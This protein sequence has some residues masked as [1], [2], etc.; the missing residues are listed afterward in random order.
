VGKIKKR[1]LPV[2]LCLLLCCM[3]SPSALAADE[4]EE[5]EAPAETV[6]SIV[7]MESFL[8]FAENCRLDTYSQ[9]LHVSL[10][11]DLDFS[12]VD[13]EPVPIFSG[14]LEGNGHTISG[15]LLERDGSVQGLFR[16]LT[17]EALVQN[18][19]VKAE[20]RP[21]GSHNNVGGIV[22]S[23]AG[24]I[25]NCRFY[26]SVSGGDCV[27]GIAGVNTMTGIIER[28]R[29]SGNVTGSHFVGGLVGDNAGVVRSSSNSAHVNTTPAENTVDLNDI[30]LESIS[31]TESVSTVTD[32]GGIAGISS[33][34]IRHSTNRG[35]V[36]YQQMGYNIGGIAGTQK[37]YI[38]GCENFGSVNGRKEVGGIVGQ[39]EPVIRVLYTKDT[40]QIL[41]EQL[42]GM[43][44]IVNQASAHT[45]SGTAA[46]NGQINILSGQVGDAAL[47]VDKLLDDSGYI[48]G[49]PDRDTMQAIENTL[50]ASMTD[51]NVT[52]NNMA[53]ATEK[54]MYALVGDLQALAGQI[55][56]MS[57]TI[58][59][60]TENV[61]MSFRDVSDQDTP[62][63]LSGKV[64][65]CINYGPVLAD[66]NAGGV[67]GA[68]APENDLNG[69]ENI[70]YSGEDSMNLENEFRAVILSCDNKADV[71][72]K[73][74]NGGGVVGW[75]SMGLVYEC[76]NIGT[77]DAENADY[78][79][80]IAGSGGGF[81]RQCYSSCSI[82]GDSSLGGIAGKGTIVTDCR[83]MVTLEG[84]EKIGGILGEA[85]ESP[86]LPEAT[87]S[88]DADLLDESEEA[89]EK[90][91]VS[92]NFYVTLG[93]DIGA[94]DGIS[95]AG[96]AEPLALDAFMQ[97]ED[98]PVEFGTVVVRFRFE[99][100]TEKSISLVPGGKLK[101]SQL[102]A[103]PEKAGFTGCWS[104][105]EEA[106]LDH[107]VSDLVFNAEYSAKRPTIE[108]EELR[109]NEIPVMLAQGLFSGDQIMVL[110]ALDECPALSAGES[111][112]ES[113]AFS[114]PHGGEVTRLRFALPPGSGSSTVRLM[115]RQDSGQWLD[116]ECVM[117]G[118]YVVFDVQPEDNALC[119]INSPNLVLT[120]G[121]CVGAVAA[122][123]LA[124][125]LRS[126]LR[127][128]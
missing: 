70:L 72:V 84:A 109:D 32:I 93:R 52:L 59:Q 39:M 66:V 8:L 56:A 61:G 95:Y 112:A 47:A 97:L 51:I 126:K 120:V 25:K 65:K 128:K 119:L 122:V 85:E 96:S 14:V 17:E 100:G 103:V 81:I 34:V 113:W 64:E 62:E 94:V 67:S 99:D 45:Q 123:Y 24:L 83:S 69:Y 19:I 44:G 105:L 107:I 28:C 79:G 110:T 26:G 16:Y 46:M 104:G 90:P 88:E 10:E 124:L 29:V 40:L 117:E 23:N 115:V 37:G 2:F 13:F 41:G 82:F 53:A 18:L 33:G 118:R 98:I 114:F 111:W 54:T 68:I 63:D 9:G 5:P 48:G 12:G 27:G 80:G 77:I 78:L 89:Q 121:L 42:D 21:Q 91:P 127:K 3:V 92:G 101:E 75:M 30:T 87:E 7:D 22:G 38:V 60:A 1:I 102:P 108:S 74:Q 15:V 116:R 57:E 31:S 20:I 71:S 35:V 43:S 4:Q 86:Q 58:D 11:A 49:I 106:D 36:G 76:M 50:S 6:V 73:K 55:N 125:L